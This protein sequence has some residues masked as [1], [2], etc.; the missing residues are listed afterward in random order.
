[1]TPRKPRKRC[2]DCPEGSQRPTPHEGPRCATHWRIVRQR[3]AQSRRDAFV[4]RTY[5]LTPD[6]YDALIEYQGG[7]CA[8]CGWATG[9]TRRLSVDHQHKR[10]GCDHPP[11]TACKACLRGG[12]C[13]VCND[14]LGYIRD[15][16]AAL[17]RGYWYLIEPPARTLFKGA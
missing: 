7:V 11:E 17:A 6:E 3:R 2:I 13:R 12:L 16:P 15:D 10:E 9:R 8:F 4:G 5:G 14:F 1:M